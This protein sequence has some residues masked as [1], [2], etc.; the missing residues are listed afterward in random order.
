M[1]QVFHFIKI[2]IAVCAGVAGVVCLFVAPNL[3]VPLGVTS[4]AWS[5]M[6]E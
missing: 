3:V 4:L 1:N 5:M 6:P 2:A